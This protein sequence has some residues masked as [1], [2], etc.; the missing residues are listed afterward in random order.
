MRAPHAGWEITP[1]RRAHHSWSSLPP[2]KRTLRRS[3]P[4]EPVRLTSAVQTSAMA[5]DPVTAAAAPHAG[6]LQYGAVRVS[7]GRTSALRRSLTYSPC[8]GLGDGVRTRFR[9]LLRHRLR[10]PG[11]RR[12]GCGDRLRLRRRRDAAVARPAAVAIRR[13]SR[14]R[15]SRVPASGRRSAVASLVRGRRLARRQPC[16]HRRGGR[17][18]P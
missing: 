17:L 9:L 5:I 7:G 14:P 15:R 18:A 1:L 13:R 16:G 12:T 11:R 4:S 6:S 8:R 3:A 10:S 2:S